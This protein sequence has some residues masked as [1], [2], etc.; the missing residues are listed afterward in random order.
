[1][2]S[3]N[4]A[5]LFTDPLRIGYPS[6]R[7]TLTGNFIP[8]FLVPNITIQEAFEPLIEI[9]MTFTNQLQTRLSSE[10]ADN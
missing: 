7:D 5:L 9:D 10:K 4:T 6:F 8:Y 2:N 1:M 3:F